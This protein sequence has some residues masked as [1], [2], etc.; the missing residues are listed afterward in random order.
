MTFIH[1]FSLIFQVEMVFHY[2]KQIFTQGVTKILQRIQDQYSEI[3][4]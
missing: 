4:Q 3:L 2:K 1:F